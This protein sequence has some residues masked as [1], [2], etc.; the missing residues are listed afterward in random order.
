MVKTVFE[1]ARQ[2][3]REAHVPMISRLSGAFLSRVSSI[4]FESFWAKESLLP[5]YRCYLTLVI[6]GRLRVTLVI[7]R[8]GEMLIYS[9][10]MLYGCLLCIVRFLSYMY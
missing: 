3:F 7:M 8:N 2:L 1:K 10:I 4:L 5:F 6:K 9:F